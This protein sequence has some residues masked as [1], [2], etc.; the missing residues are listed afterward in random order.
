MEDKAANRSQVQKQESLV[1]PSLCRADSGIFS[2]APAKELDPSFFWKLFADSPLAKTGAVSCG[3]LLGTSAASV[4]KILTRRDPNPGSED[5]LFGIQREKGQN[6]VFFEFYPQITTQKDR[7]LT[8]ELNLVVWYRFRDFV[9][10]FPK[11]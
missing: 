10:F 5:Q 9:F 6:G 11:F 3:L 8:R 2:S 7:K 1:K 4:P